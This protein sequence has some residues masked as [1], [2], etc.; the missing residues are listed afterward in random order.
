[1]L[2]LFWKIDFKIIVCAIKEN[3]IKISLVMLFVAVIEQF[4]IFFV[5]ATNKLTAI[6]NLIF[7]DLDS[8]IQMREN[9]GCRFRF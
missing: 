9:I 8:V 2:I 7:R 4:N 1:M 5:R 6:I 3:V